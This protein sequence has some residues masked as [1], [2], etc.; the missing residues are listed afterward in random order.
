MGRSKS[1]G[2]AVDA[3]VGP[4][5]VAGW[6]LVDRAGAAQAGGTVDLVQRPANDSA[7]AEASAILQA[8]RHVPRGETL[9]TDAHYVASEMRNPKAR[10]QISGRIGEI[11]DRARERGIKIRWARRTHRQIRAAHRAAQGEIG[12]SD[13]R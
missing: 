4:D 10:G 8:L 11:Q 2:W 13:T 5:G 12:R 7:Q 3:H 9:L 6:A 1:E